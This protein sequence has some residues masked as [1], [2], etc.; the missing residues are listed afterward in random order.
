M[1]RS[2]TVFRAVRGLSLLATFG[3]IAVLI[4]GCTSQSADD[5]SA[6]SATGAAVLSASSADSSPYNGG[7]AS[8]MPL[9]G[10]AS[11]KA[12]TAGSG[13]TGQEDRPN[14]AAP[15]VPVSTSGPVPTSGNID[16]EVPART[17][18]TN[19]PVALDGTADFGNKISA[20][21]TEVKAVDATAKQ[22]GEVA[23]PAVAVTVEV[24]NTSR[25]PIG[26][27]T[28]SVTLAD[29]AG[30]P[31]SP[32]STDP[33]KPLSGVLTPGQ[34]QSGTYIFTVP[35]NTRDRLTVSVSYSTGA[36]TVLFTGSL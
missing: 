32:V 22:P 29:E 17:V 26:L 36:P 15:S 25:Q 6:D 1:R 5:G 30:N 34:Q 23:G 4:V 31:G 28:V 24:S 19:A 2:V 10:P 14:L 3:A 12:S 16:Q 35:K 11:T 21:L 7:I 33:A 8:S 20:R 18:P 13:S 27:D 9:P